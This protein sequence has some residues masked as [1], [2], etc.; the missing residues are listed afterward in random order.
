MTSKMSFLQARWPRIKQWSFRLAEFGFVQGLVQ[1]L[2]AVA[3]LLIVRTI[4]K[5]E[6]ALFAITNSMLT[7]CNLMADLGIGMGVRSIGGRVWQ[8]RDRFGQLM[9]TALA[10]RRRFALVSFS[11]CLPITWWMLSHN[12]ASLL[13][14][15][16]L[17]LIVGVSVIPLLNTSVWGVSPGLHGEYRR[18]QKLDFGNAI[19][20]LALIGILAAS[21]INALL[22]TAVGGITNWIQA[23]FYRRWAKEKADF[24]AQ[25]NAA[26]H[27]ELMR[28]SLKS[29]PNTIFFC[30]QG[31]VTL[32]ILTLVGSVTGI[33]NIMALGRVAALFT[34]FSITFSNVLAPRFMRCQDQ[35]R[36]P[37]LYLLLVG[38]SLLVSMPL[39]AFA[40]LWPG[41]F[42]WLLGGKYTG[43]EHEYG[44]VVAAACVAQVGGVMW[45]LN[46]SKA[47]IRIQAHAF[48]PAILGVQFVAAVSLD[49]HQFHDV[50][51]FNFASA[52]APLPIYLLDAWL[53]FRD[54]RAS[55][56]HS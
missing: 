54:S 10:L 12:N 44:W 34:V 13:Y 52:A 23:V 51:I 19:L 53:G 50:I 40:W 30:F 6:Y 46:S 26:D 21:R 4:S 16:F 7:T 47:W 20:R 14:A 1:L 28:L 31:Q 35:R 15:V 45:V 29:L 8:D 22:A 18:I 32:L 27:R 2:T 9:N 11:I 25:T 17:C 36:L 39:M 41:P 38:G 33:A 49:L 55:E 37:R 43:L 56:K 3:G 48:I 5:P 24:A 42:L